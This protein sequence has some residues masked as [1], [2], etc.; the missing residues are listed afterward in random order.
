MGPIMV[1]SCMRSLSAWCPVPWLCGAGSITVN[2]KHSVWQ[3]VTA[4]HG[5]WSLNLSLVGLGAHAQPGLS[6][7]ASK[8]V[9]EQLGS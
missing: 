1:V 5:G 8:A 9:V 3:V 2:L 6:G 4:Y 7:F